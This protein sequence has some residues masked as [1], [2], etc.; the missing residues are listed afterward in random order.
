M[1]PDRAGWISLTHSTVFVFEGALVLLPLEGEPTLLLEPGLTIAQEPCIADVRAGSLQS[2][3][4]Q[5]LT[6]RSLVELLA[7]KVPSGVIGIETWDRFPIGLY[8]AVSE[9]LQ[10]IKLAPSTIV[11]ELRLI[12]SDYEIA[13][14]RQCA[15]VGDKGHQVIVDALRRGE[16]Q[17]EQELIRAAEYAMRRR[18][19]RSGRS[20]TSSQ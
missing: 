19:V 16:P 9:Q 8:I 14:Q 12:K 2:S 3:P 7:E 4:D 17:S 11:E 13:I 20:W 6:P 1:F 15:A 18:G 5:G 10:G